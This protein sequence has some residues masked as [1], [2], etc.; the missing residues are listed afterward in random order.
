MKRPLFAFF[1]VLAIS[2]IG[3]AFYIVPMTEQVIITQFGRPIGEPITEPGLH[4]KMPFIQDVNRIEKRVLEWDGQPLR[5]QTRDKVFINVDSFARWRIVDPLK[6]LVSLR[7]ERTALSRLDDLIGGTTQGEVAKHDL[8]EL[9]RTDK[10]R[11]TPPV[12]AELSEAIRAGTGGSL[13]PIKLGRRII[14]E[15]IKKHAAPRILSDFGIELLDV[16]C[17]RLNYG[18]DVQAKIY[19]RMASERKQI[20][21][22]FR[23]EGLGEAA[24][25]NGDRQREVS[26]ISSE[27]YRKVAEINGKA[28]AEATR[29]YAEAYNSSPQAVEFYSFQRSLETFGKII[30]SET[31]MVLS[32]DAELFKMMKTLTPTPPGASTPAGSPQ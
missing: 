9:I 20:A 27:A 12:V 25:I 28:D 4:F 14:E 8:I 23:S 30:D 24:R 7:D 10:D 22:A 18:E 6:F 2:V 17:K 29:I 15:E 5:M 13:R 26:R 1:A 32:T 16:R 19:E 11:K 31:T 21:E 3:G